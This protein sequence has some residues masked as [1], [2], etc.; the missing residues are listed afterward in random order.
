MFFFFFFFGKPFLMDLVD[1]I[2]QLTPKLVKIVLNDDR[3]WLLQVSFN[4]HFHEVCV[5]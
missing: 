5:F 2:F 4:D 3:E 1:Q